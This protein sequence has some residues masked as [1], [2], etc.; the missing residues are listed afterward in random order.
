MPQFT[1][2]HTND[3]HNRLDQ[4]SSVKLNRLKA[5]HDAILLDSGDAAW[6]GNVYFRP[7]GEPIFDLMNDAEYDAMSAGNREFHFTAAGFASKLSRARFPILCANIRPSGTQAL[8]TKPWIIIEKHGVLVG[9]FGLTVP[10]VTERMRTASFSAYVFSNPIE[11]A[12]IAVG[13]LRK[14]C[15][16]LVALTHIGLKRDTEL[17]KQCSEI[18]LIVGG[19]SHDIL[20]EPRMVNRTAIV[21][22]GSYARNVGIVVV[23]GRAGSWDVSGRLEPLLKDAH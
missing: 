18:D 17:A 22:T 3:F 11:A 1:I 8:P 15:D 13:E 10:M 6:A 21:Q 5:E 4:S 14:K 19:H 12:Q 16:Y 9:V 20:A 7:G 2:L 23:N